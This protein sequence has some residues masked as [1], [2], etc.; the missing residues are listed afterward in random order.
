MHGPFR[1]QASAQGLQR[2]SPMLQGSTH[3]KSADM[4][5]GS[6]LQQ[7]WLHETAFLDPVR[8]LLLCGSAGSPRAS[9]LN[10][11]MFC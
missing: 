9:I 8:L 2:N 10:P 7:A 4:T 11:E 6:S 5:Q 1:M 3:L